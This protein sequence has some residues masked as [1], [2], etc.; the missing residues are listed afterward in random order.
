MKKPI[1]LM[2]FFCIDEIERL[3]IEILPVFCYFVRLILQ[4]IKKIGVCHN[5]FTHF[6]LHYERKCL[7][8]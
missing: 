3:F 7:Y 5:F 4:N 8:L 6:Y 2:G 1:V